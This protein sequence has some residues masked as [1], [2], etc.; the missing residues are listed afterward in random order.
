MYGNG[1]CKT[2]TDADGIV[3]RLPCPDA[4]GYML[5]LFF[6]VG[7]QLPDLT[8]FVSGTSLICAFFEISM[9][10]VPPK[11][12]QR[13]FPPMVSGTVILMIGASLVGTSGISN[14]GGGSNCQSRPTTGFF[15]LCPDIS[16]PRPLPYVLLRQ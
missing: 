15:Q 5:G 11:I 2:T 1:V 16:A 3:T 10:L 8:K 6:S 9:S 7:L 4:Y 14:W 13:I 12:L